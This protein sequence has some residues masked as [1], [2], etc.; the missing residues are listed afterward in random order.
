MLFKKLLKSLDNK[1]KLYGEKETEIT[2]VIDDSRK[3]KKGS[4]FVAIKGLH[5]DG[6]EFI[7]EVI[8]KGVAAVVG[9]IEPDKKWLGKIIYVKV[10]NSRKAL[11][12]LASSWWKNPS[13]R[14]KIIGVTGTDGKTTTASIIY[15]ILKKA[16]LR[17]GLVSSVSAKL[18]GREV[19]TGFHV[20]N[21]EPLALHRFLAE[22]VKERIEFAVLEVTSHGIKQ[23]RVWGIPF[24]V[25]VLTNI[26]PEHLDY[27]KTM[28][29][30][31][32]TKAQLFRGVSYAIL[33]NSDS[34]F[35]RIKKYIPKKVKIIAYPSLTLEEE[36]KNAIQN[37]FPE[38]YNRLNA[39]AS[40]MVAKIY[41][42]TADK[43]TDAINTF[44][45]V[46]GRLE[47]IIN[48][49]GLKIYVDFAHTPNALKS[50]L[51]ELKKNTKGRL[52]SVFG[53]A[54]ERDTIKRSVMGVISASIADIT[55]FTAEDPRSEKIE[56]IIKEMVSRIEKNIAL[57]A[58]INYLSSTDYDNKHLYLRIP[59]RGE[60]ISYAIQKL[61]KKGDT[62]VICGK[63]H[64]KSM[65]YGV[66][67]YPWSDQDAVRVALKG[68]VKEIPRHH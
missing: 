56:N 68:G 14:L 35:Y 49:K 28:K 3:C 67:E 46:S 11:A 25:G 18:G 42:I 51:K 12:Q 64:E 50:V 61:S 6:H 34:S 66:K 36:I 48:D 16:G 40:C 39:E 43:I 44:P 55:I 52:I 9:E 15:W 57:E 38:S 7:N 33:N 60:A 53:C 8:G 47:E 4:M 27:H 24:E 21:P 59:E 13:A 5:V 62:V 2:S 17:V 30:Y 26:T 32:K 41:N 19:D 58:E 22:M 31:I 65:A 63:G 45:Q 29:D 37:K 10:P 1:Y 23:L 20:T 54:G